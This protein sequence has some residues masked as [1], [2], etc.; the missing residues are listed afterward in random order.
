MRP[1]ENARRAGGALDA[2]WVAHARVE[3]PPR[4]VAQH[5]LL[6]GAHRLLQPPRRHLLW[7]LQRKVG[8]QRVSGVLM[9]NDEQLCSGAPAAVSAACA[10][11]LA[12][13]R[14]LAGLGENHRERL[15]AGG[16]ELVVVE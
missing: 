11:S 14:A 13:R 3:P 5:C 1:R 9:R 4:A 12:P 2:L 6:H 8:V 7:L 10:A 16:G 15:Q